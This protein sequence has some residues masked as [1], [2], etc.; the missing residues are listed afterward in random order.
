MQGSRGTDADDA[1][2]I[3]RS[4]PP[5]ATGPGPGA[6]GARAAL[7]W[8]ARF[9]M[10]GMVLSCVLWLPLPFLPFLPVEASTK[11]WAAGGLVAAAE[12]LWWGGAALAGPEAVRRL[13]SWWR[14]R[15]RA[16][17]ADG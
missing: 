4:E 8:P 13:R 3:Q 12:L 11:A 15:P 1:G 7:G 17:S 14:R 10:A 9:G 2:P 6:V 5:S 16:L